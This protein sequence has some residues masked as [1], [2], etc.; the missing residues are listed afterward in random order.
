MASTDQR[1]ERVTLPELA[2]SG[3]YEMNKP[4]RYFEVYERYFAPL[5]DREMTL[6]E[7]GVDRGGSLLLWRDYFRKATVVGLDIRNVARAEGVH[8]YEGSQDDR[9]LL[10]RIASERAPEGF[11]VVIDDGSHLA[12]H[13]ERSFWHLFDRRLRPGGIY[14][15]E[16]W[17][18]G[19][20]REWPDGH[21]W[22]P[23]RRSRF[24]PTRWPS[25]DYGMVGFVKQLIDE[26]AFGDVTHPKRGGP[27][28]PRPS[29]FDHMHVI[30]GLA[31]VVKAH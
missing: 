11:D 4:P 16:D 9:A 24:R 2:A 3:D 6:L 14:A 13:A 23:P 20:W 18:T 25:H 29:R 12:R 15:I 26:Q 28:P 30:Q 1:E 27:G 7:I 8:V 22:A 5:R 31:V 17:G 19:Y 21:V 10:D